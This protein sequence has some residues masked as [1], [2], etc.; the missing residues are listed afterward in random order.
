MLLRHYASRFTP[1]LFITMRLRCIRL[2]IR[3]T[4]PIDYADDIAYMRASVERF[5]ARLC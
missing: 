2:L 3:F 5:A 4:L 1:C